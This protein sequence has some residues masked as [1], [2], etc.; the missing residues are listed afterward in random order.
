MN[1]D[2][3]VNK[4][5]LYFGFSGLN[6]GVERSYD[7]PE[8]KFSKYGCYCTPHAAN[9][10]HHIW[11]GKGDPVDAIDEQC[12]HLWWAYKCLSKDFGPSCDS[13][14]AYEW[15]VDNNGAI[16]CGMFHL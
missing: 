10:A 9:V 11:V 6:S 14:V 4:K 8:D 5:Y 12:R 13:T 2:T 16:A 1:R 3:N 15:N 7:E